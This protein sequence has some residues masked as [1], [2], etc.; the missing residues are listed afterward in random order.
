VEA[1]LVILF[2]NGNRRRLLYRL[3]LLRKADMQL[4]LWALVLSAKTGQN[5]ILL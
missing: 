5:S 3:P 1:S 4:Y 2:A